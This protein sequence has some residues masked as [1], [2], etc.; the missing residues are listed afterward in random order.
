MS[1]QHQEDNRDE[2][3]S[4]PSFEKIIG[5]RSTRTSKAVHDRW[6]PSV[7][8]EDN[9]VPLNSNQYINSSF[10]TFP[11]SELMFIVTQNPVRLLGIDTRPLFWE[12]VVEQ[13][14]AFI[15]SLVG[16]REREVD[17]DIPLAYWPYQDAS[18]SVSVGSDEPEAHG[19]VRRR[20]FIISDRT[21]GG[22]TRAVT[23]VNYVSWPDHGVVSD[24]PGFVAIVAAFHADLSRKNWPPVLVHC[25]VGLGRSAVFIACL[26][27]YHMATYQSVPLN[28]VSIMGLVLSM[29]H[30]RSGAVQKSEQFKMIVDFA[31]YVHNKRL[32]GSGGGGG[33]QHTKQYALFADKRYGTV[34]NTVLSGGEFASE[35][36]CRTYKSAHPLYTEGEEESA[37]SNRSGR[38]ISF[39]KNGTRGA[40]YAIPTVRTLPVQFALKLPLSGGVN[41]TN[42]EEACDAMMAFWQDVVMPDELLR[43]RLVRIVRRTKNGF[44]MERMHGSVFDIMRM[45][46]KQTLVAGFIPLAKTLFRMHESGI[47]HYDAHASNVLYRASPMDSLMLK[48]A[49]L[50]SLISTASL[51]LPTRRRVGYTHLLAALKCSKSK[52][53]AATWSISDSLKAHA[54]ACLALTFLDMLVPNDILGQ[55]SIDPD[56]HPAADDDNDNGQRARNRESGYIDEDDEDTPTAPSTRDVPEFFDSSDTTLKHRGGGGGGRSNLFLVHDE[57]QI[58][59]DAG[60]HKMIALARASIADSKHAHAW[61]NFVSTALLNPDPSC[62]Q[63]SEA[64]IQ[65]L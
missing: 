43:T 7:P 65:Y 40:V 58:D 63:E 19:A 42:F 26:Q 24:L 5:P 18:I 30:Q 16:A 9:V 62:V 11:R 23:Q 38:S 25:K 22:A 36:A 59:I 60:L 55:L 1:H 6:G 31:K 51:F 56:Y 8:F 32:N 64:A 54:Y 49:D 12:L 14:I 3:D 39:L 61:I 4:E 35:D 21:T 34:C 15:V 41:K 45:N 17:S 37:A 33:V 50:D 47:S 20:E 52:A 53:N 57:S 44:V 27:L 28:T 10:I 29:R 2:F 46:M 13:K 48:F